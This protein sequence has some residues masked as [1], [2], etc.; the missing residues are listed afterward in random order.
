[1]DHNKMRLTTEDIANLLGV[2]EKTVYNYIKQNK[3][4]P[5]NKDTWHWDGQYYFYKEDIDIDSLLEKKPGN[6]TGEVAE[7]LEVSQTTVLKYIKN[8]Q[9]KASLHF[10]KGREM[11]FIDEEEVNRFIESY[12]RQKRYEKKTFY[13]KE[14]GYCLFQ[15]FFNSRLNK[16]ARITEI[17]NK[18]IKVLV[19][20][21]RY[22]GLQE[23]LLEGF[24]PSYLIKEG[25]YN[26]KKGY[27]KF[28]FTKPRQIKST[29]YKIIDLFYQTAGPLNIRLFEEEDMIEIE[30]KPTLVEVDRKE[31]MDEINMLQQS[32][33]NGNVS[34]VHNGV[35]IDSDLEVL[36]MYIPSDLKDVI[37]KRAERE[38]LTM[39]ELLAKVVRKEFEV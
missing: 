17:N 28:R 36:Q 18:G 14:H 23:L 11:Y 30:I 13:S 22:L 20:D 31:Y 24:S 12:S 2:T 29:T 38:N 35:L 8:G 1:M 6:T 5:F 32:L 16:I 4:V 39:D 34:V 7:L 19:E 10:Y 15:L 3:I 25:K 33:I 9:L 27:A 21:G 37:K 26:T